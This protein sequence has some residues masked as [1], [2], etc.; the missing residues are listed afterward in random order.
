MKSISWFSRIVVPSLLFVILS[1]HEVVGFVVPIIVVGGERTSSSSFSLNVAGV[2]RNNDEQ[3]Q[4]QSALLNEFR[5]AS[6]ELIDPYKVLKVDRDSTK[7][8]IKQA[9]R[10]MS[11]KYHPDQIRFQDMMPGSWYVLSTYEHEHTYSSDTI[12]MMMI[13]VTSNCIHELLLFVVDI[14]FFFSETQITKKNK[15]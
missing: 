11:R 1:R 7:E 13:H 6:G 10:K 15:K 8:Q 5:I 3:Q 4:Q 9:Y 14:F 2:R 12:M